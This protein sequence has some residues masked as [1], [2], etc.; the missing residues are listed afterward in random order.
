[1]KEL[2][3]LDKAVEEL[4][5]QA[6]QLKEFNEVYATISALS[7]SIATSETY[8]NEIKSKLSKANDQIGEQYKSFSNK[9]VELYEDQKRFFK[10]LDI[11]IAS[12]YE[13]QTS[14]LQVEIRRE[15][16]NLQKVFDNSLESR[17][18]EIDKQNKRR[19]NVIVVFLIIIALISSISITLPFI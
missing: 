10:E 12:R 17:L 15:I 6:E 11:T 4:E 7:S 16:N 8:L 5:S 13:R 1:M 19:M 18:R 2:K 9:V 14:E 3:K